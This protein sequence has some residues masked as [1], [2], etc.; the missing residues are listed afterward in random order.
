MSRECLI[1]GLSTKV[2]RLPWRG[3][4]TFGVRKWEDKVITGSQQGQASTERAVW[5]E[6]WPLLLGY[7]QPQMTMQDWYAVTWPHWSPAFRPVISATSQPRPA[8]KRPKAPTDT[9]YI[10]M[11]ALG[12]R[13]V[14]VEGRPGEVSR[15]HPHWM[16]PVFS[17]YN[18]TYYHF[19]SYLILC[20]STIYLY[21]TFCFINIFHYK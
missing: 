2:S 13:A 5:Q 20:Q 12:H 6:L 1:K 10:Q 16:V 7:Q 4:T 15:K 19:N 11:K 14:S 8:A 18:F 21:R 17:Y 3:I 9:V